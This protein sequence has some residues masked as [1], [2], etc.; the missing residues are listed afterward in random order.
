[1]VTNTV[2]EYVFDS[3]VNFLDV[4]KEDG[5]NAIMVTVSG[6]SSLQVNN[7]PFWIVLHEY[8]EQ[9]DA[10]SVLEDLNKKHVRITVTIVD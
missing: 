6:D 9:E 7:I 2:K 8:L 5:G 3:I 10:T 4:K 1:M